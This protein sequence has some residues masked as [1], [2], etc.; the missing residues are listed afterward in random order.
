[1]PKQERPPSKSGGE[2]R[3]GRQ[4]Q[5][6]R[7]Q[8]SDWKR[9][10]RLASSNRFALARP[11]QRNCSCLFEDRSFG[12]GAA[13]NKSCCSRRAN[14][15]R[16]APPPVRKHPAEAAPEGLRWLRVLRTASR[17]LEPPPRPSVLAK[18]NSLQPA[19][20]SG[21]GLVVF[22]HLP[23]LT[24]GACPPIFRAWHIPF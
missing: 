17:N 14:R 18:H 5:K 8:R 22:H 24:H 15:R 20:T 1:M 7:S 6:R 3:Q 13:G 10:H 12:D 11:S 23:V 19:L 4:E 16:K 2:G 9:R 21:G